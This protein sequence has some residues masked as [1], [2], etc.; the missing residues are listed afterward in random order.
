MAAGKHSVS[1][2]KRDSKAGRTQD[3]QVSAGKAVPAAGAKPRHK[4]GHL[5][6]LFAVIVVIAVV[7]AAFVV[8]P[9]L[10][11]KSADVREGEQITVEVA[12][13]STSS[14][15][16]KTLK[17][18]GVIALESDFLNAVKDKGVADQLK[19]GT[20][21]FT[22]GED[23]SSIIDAMV[24]GNAGYTLLVPEGYALKKIAKTVQKS[25][26]IDADDFYK[27]ATSASDY[28]GDYPFL[29]DAYDNSMEGFLFPDTYTVPFGSTAD[30]VIRMML[31]NYTT[32]IA[33]VDMSYA[34]SKNLTTYDVLI[35][36]SMIE[37]ESRE[38]SDKT[39][40]SSVF[41]NRLHAN[42]NLGSDVTTYYAVGKD[43][44]ED[45]TNEDLAS[46]SPYNTRNPNKKGLPA[47][48]ICSPGLVSLNAAA[49]P[50]ETSY[51]YFF[52]SSK[53]DKTMFYKDQASFDK[54]WAKLQ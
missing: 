48:P 27:L 37:K 1:K 47:G 46:D 9:N 6:I 40:I 12:E 26:S 35:L 38:D 28:Q 41:Y 23:V 20:Y 8:L 4:Q 11:E 5:G 42:M 50:D 14:A 22:G 2:T 34:T 15:I 51:L 19:A 36:A 21:I 24:A 25:C 33:S 54:A 30:D 52:Y 13:G 45:L 44:T 31:D 10:G 3:T 7:V 53:K 49:H 29:A 43:L 32:Q 17:D 18:D 16:A 39:S